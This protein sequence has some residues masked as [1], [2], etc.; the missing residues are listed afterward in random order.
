MLT[1]TDVHAAL[2][3][4]A[5]R[6]RRS[7]PVR[8]DAS[9]YRIADL[10]ATPGAADVLLAQRDGAAARLSIGLPS[11]GAPQYWLYAEPEDAA[12]WVGQLLV[13]I[14]EEVFTGGLG[15][16]CARELRGDESYVVVTNYGWQLTDGAEHA[17]LTAAA[18]P[19]GWHGAGTL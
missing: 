10:R 5:T 2:R 17:R 13:W 12:D 18:G 6:W 4:A 3:A 8:E 9:D 16:A 1:D 19:L 7:D 14:D 11:S 15:P